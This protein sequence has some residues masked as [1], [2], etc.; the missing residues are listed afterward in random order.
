M[1]FSIPTFWKPSDAFLHGANPTVGGNCQPKVTGTSNDSQ[2]ARYWPCLDPAIFNPTETL[3]V[4]DWMA[5]SASLG[6]KEIC[7]TAKHFGGFT[8][9]PSNH[10]NYSVAASP[11]MNGKGDVVRLFADAANRWGIKICYYCNPLDDGHMAQKDGVDAAEFQTRQLG[12][13]KELMDNYGLVPL[14]LM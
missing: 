1:H 8:L 3:D 6:M 10:T 7:L 4:D 14:L 9:W 5:A 2:T 13:L 12:M 11:W